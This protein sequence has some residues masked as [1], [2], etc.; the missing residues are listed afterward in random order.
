MARGKRGQP[1][2]S[3]R[4][5]APGGPGPR[6]P[7]RRLRTLAAEPAVTPTRSLPR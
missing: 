2:M 4:R 5:Q 7:T 6:P 3:N 1:I